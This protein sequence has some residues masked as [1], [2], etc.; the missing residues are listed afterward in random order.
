MQ[1]LGKIVAQK[2]VKQ[3]E[4]VTSAGRGK[5]VTLCCA[6]NA[7]GHSV[8]P[9]FIFPRVRYHERLVDGGP[10]GCIGVSHKSGWMTQRTFCYF[11]STL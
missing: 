8:P 2:G 10:P 4:A 11:L 5:L 1:N 7:L 3:V 9:M 6:V